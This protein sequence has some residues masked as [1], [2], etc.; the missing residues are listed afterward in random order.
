MATDDDALALDSQLCFPLYAATRAM[1]QAYQPLLSALG[2][3]YP[4][5]LVL[6]VLWEHD[7]ASVK[8]IGERLF[9][10]SGTLTPLLKRLEVAGV[11]KRKRST[12]DERIV[13]IH[14]SARGKRLKQKAT[15]IPD[16]LAC[17]IGLDGREV[18]RVRGNL[19]RLFELL[20]QAGPSAAKRAASRGETP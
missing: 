3:T 1:M 2:L 19:K 15:G 7:G 12:V 4:Q 18:A 11:V 9:L 10:D 5:Y 8:Q 6:L 14:L 13:E 16:E 17:R 20:Q